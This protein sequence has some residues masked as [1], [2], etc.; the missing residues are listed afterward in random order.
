MTYF[1]DMQKVIKR[2]YEIGKVF[3]QRNKPNP[4]LHK[5]IFCNLKGVTHLP[6]RFNQ[7]VRSKKYKAS[8]KKKCKKSRAINHI[9]KPTIEF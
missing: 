1:R 3:F 9:T 4:Y 2:K 6:L 5:E 8:L 7:L